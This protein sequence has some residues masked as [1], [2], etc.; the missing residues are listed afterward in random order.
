MQQILRNEALTLF[1]EW[2]ANPAW[3]RY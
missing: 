3:T 2:K 1:D